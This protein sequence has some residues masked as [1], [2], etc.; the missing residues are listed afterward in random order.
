MPPLN[1]K[2]LKPSDIIDIVSTGAA[3]ETDQCQQVISF[4]K[5][6]GFTPRLSQGLTA[7]SCPY[8]A[9]NDQQRYDDFIDATQASD[10]KAIWCVRGGYGTTRLMPHLLNAPIPQTPKLLLGY[11]DVTALHILVNHYWNWTS[12]HAPV[13]LQAINHTLDQIYFDKVKEILL[14]QTTEIAFKNLMPLNQAARSNKTI[15]SSMTGGNLS[16]LQTSLGTNW[17]INPAKQ[18]IFIE[19]IAERGYRLDRMFTHLTQAGI[20]TQAEAVILGDFTGGDEE[21]GQN[22]IPYAISEFAQSL[23]IPVLQL[24][25][26]GHGKSN[27]PLP[28]YSKTSLTLGTQPL[29]ICQTQESL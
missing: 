7:G 3:I 11:S 9:S 2:F 20:F 23:P 12:L 14:G 1:W 22:F 29:L 26:I 16:L 24:T 4:I 6:L 13:L 19:E 18:I 10:S 8:Y 17:Q 25:G 15:H 5:K 28:L 21:T 27:L